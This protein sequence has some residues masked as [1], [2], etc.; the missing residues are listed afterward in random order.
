MTPTRTLV[1]LR[2]AKS[3]YPGGVRDHD[4]PLADRGRHEGALAGEWLRRHVPPID[5]VLCSTA[6]RT[7]ETV[8]VAG[9]L[10]PMRR[11]S[12]IY[13]ATPDEILGEVALTDPSIRTLLVVGHGPG[14][15]GLALEL[16]G[17]ASD[18]AALTQLSRR[19]P[20]SAIAVLEIAGEWA[21]LAGQ[22]GRL[23]GVHIPRDVPP[24]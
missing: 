6:A 24:G 10:A 20:T 3:G 18:Q 4:R 8:S 13:E 1:L 21:E 7:L 17:P 12:A 19:F 14:L 5:Q 23:T 15:P 11:S 9:V 22:D 16:A 2:H